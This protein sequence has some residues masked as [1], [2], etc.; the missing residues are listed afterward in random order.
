MTEPT[1]SSRPVSIIALNWCD[2]RANC[3]FYVSVSEFMGKKDH[4]SLTRT[5]EDKFPELFGFEY[6][7]LLM[8]DREDGGLFKISCPIESPESADEDGGA[9]PEQTTSSAHK[10][11]IVRLPRDRGLTGLTIKTE[12]ILVAADGEYNI[13]YAPEI[14][15][16]IGCQIVKNCMM[17]PCYDSQGKLRG[18]IHLLNKKNGIPISF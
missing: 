12:E 9:N 4:A 2:S 8:I 13:Q 17:G 10:P 3:A 15:N 7:G 5:F 18:L 11:I 14:D 1:S 6:C 16:C